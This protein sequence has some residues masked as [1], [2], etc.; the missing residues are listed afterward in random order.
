MSLNVKELH[1]EHPVVQAAHNDLG[2]GCGGTLPK[3]SAQFSPH[4]ARPTYYKEL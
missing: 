1:R 3:K 4:P 2:V